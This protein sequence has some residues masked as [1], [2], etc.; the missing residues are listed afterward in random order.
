[1]DD[2]VIVTLDPRVGSKRGGSHDLGPRLIE[3]G[4][5]VDT[6]VLDFGDVMFLGEGPSGPVTI[7]VEVKTIGDLVNG[8]QSGRLAGHQFP[9]LREA[10]DRVYL[11]V[12]DVSRLGRKSGLLE[13]PRGGAWRP[14]KAGR[15]VFWADVERFLVGATEAG[16][17]HWRTR[18]TEETARVIGQVLVPWWQKPY[19]QHA[20]GNVL[21]EPP[22]LQ[23]TKEDEVTQRV[24]R[25]AKVLP[26]IGNDRSKTV[27]QAFRSIWN[28]IALSTEA[29]WSAIPGIGAP[30]AR[31][32]REAIHAEIP[33][34]RRRVRAGGAAAPTRVRHAGER[35]GR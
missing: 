35:Q 22:T 16:I 31:S 12:E 20:I 30:M 28:M 34:R 19:D 10:Y 13:V 8:I 29:D 27:A 25:A 18:S 21:Y 3:L 24:R 9:G 4:V 14:L 6:A 1:M 11:I 23:L 17:P 26:G 2:P 32:I 7:G 15:P 33:G 5:L